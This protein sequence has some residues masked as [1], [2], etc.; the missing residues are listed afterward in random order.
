MRSGEL[1]SE[2]EGRNG[3]LLPNTDTGTCIKG[4]ENEGF[5]DKVFMQPF[6]EEPVR[7]ELLRWQNVI[8]L[9]MQII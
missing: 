5:R 2:D 4:E 6:V 1:Q 3:H 9:A 7:I 8:S